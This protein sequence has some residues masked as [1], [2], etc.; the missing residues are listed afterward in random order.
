MNH[1]HINYDFFELFDDYVVEYNG[2]RK[3]KAIIDRT[4]DEEKLLNLILIKYKKF[5]IYSVI[6]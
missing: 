1:D 3:N 2:L 5:K 4:T 6:F